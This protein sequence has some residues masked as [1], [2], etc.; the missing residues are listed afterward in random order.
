MHKTKVN[1]ADID[2]VKKQLIMGALGRERAARKNTVDPDEIWLNSLHSRAH[3]GYHVLLN[4]LVP[5]TKEGVVSISHIE[6]FSLENC[7]IDEEALKSP[8]KLQKLQASRGESLQKIFGLS[9]TVMLGFYELSKH[10]LAE[11]KHDEAINTFSFLCTLNPKINSFWIGL[12]LGFEAALSMNEAIDSFEIAAAC[13][14]SDFDSY[15]GLIRC[16]SQLKDFSS[17][18]NNLELAK[19][20]PVIKDQVK[21]ALAY[22][23][24]KER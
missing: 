20:N 16:C 18:K 22:I 3:K 5:F 9:N 12:G 1:D 10:L 2:F 7:Q 24:S 17:A 6:P 15:L 21:D 8:K 13:D 23:Q 4:A 14:P 11:R 19:H